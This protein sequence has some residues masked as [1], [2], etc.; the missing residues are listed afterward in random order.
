M[1][2]FK[3]GDRIRPIAADAE[4]VNG[5]WKKYF[6]E[7]H[8]S[9]PHYFVR[10]VSGSEIGVS[11]KN[12]GASV[13]FWNPSRFEPLY[14]SCAAAEVDNLA[15]EYGAARR[16]FREG[17]MVRVVRHCNW[18]GSDIKMGVPVGETRKI[19]RKSAQLADEGVDTF[20]LEGDDRYFYTPMNLEHVAPATALRIEAGKFYKTRDGRK[21]GPMFLQKDSF[22]WFDTDPKSGHGWYDCG[23]VYKGG[24]KSDSDL[25]AEWTDEPAIISFGADRVP[26]YRFTKSNPPK[27]GDRVALRDQGTFTVEKVVGDQVQF[28][29]RL[30]TWMLWDDENSSGCTL[31][32]A[33]HIVSSIADIVARHSQTGT[34]IVAVLENGQPRPA[35]RPYVHAT[36]SAAETEAS[37]LARTNPGKEFGVYTLG[38]V[39][40]VE[41]TYDHEWQWLAA[42]GDTKEAARK[43]K[44]A[45]GI[46]LQSA[47]SAVGYWLAVAA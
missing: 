38:T 15:D 45:A 10:D 39:A 44:E 17:D 40:K 13:V 36:A 23:S 18:R 8:G 33:A 5:Y 21:V 26:G 30:P 37:R 6:A 35:T 20:S 24:D 2:K 46:P 11:N 29:D 22:V 42:G 43:L 9:A 32:E 41:K 12:H 25:I 31:I 47:K 27:S 19:V 3:V 1:S 16:V 7:E 34:A 14:S 28:T 4:Y